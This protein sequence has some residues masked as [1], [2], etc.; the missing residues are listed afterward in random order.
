MKI[1]L[2]AEHA[3][4]IDMLAELWQG[5]DIR[6]A[7]R[8]DGF[9]SRGKTPWVG[10]EDIIVTTLPYRPESLATGKPTIV[11]F[12]DP[13]FPDTRQQIIDMAARGEITVVGAEHCYPDDLF[14]PGITMY[15]PF[16][17]NPRRY[18]PYTGYKPQVAVM[19]RKPEVRWGEV[20]R[21][22]TGVSMSL[23]EFFQ[24][25]PYEI[26]DEP[27]DNR[28]RLRCSQDRVLFYFSNSPYTI[29][30]FE[31]MTIGMPIVAWDH[32]H[33][34]AHEKPIH[35]YLGPGQYSIDVEQV[36]MML[37]EQLKVRFPAG[38]AYPALPVFEEVQKQW[39]TLFQ[40]VLG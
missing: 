20:V 38:V 40:S 11:Y 10:D 22:A 8:W 24:D 4:L 18:P 39:E 7:P 34:W 27:D 25:I 13:A 9:R 16:A 29:V 35:K 26:I 28:F 33:R 21:G 1:G 5:H 37:R 23:A 3:G 32:H 30:L 31:A 19:N 6:L 17:V 36:R 12:T 15:I 2:W 14:I